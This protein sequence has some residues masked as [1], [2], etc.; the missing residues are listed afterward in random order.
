MTISGHIYTPE[1]LALVLEQIRH[2]LPWIGSLDH[3]QDGKTRLGNCSHQ[4][5]SIEKIGLDICGDIEL[6]N[7]D[8]GRLA[9][10]C[11][12]ARLPAYL[13]PFIFASKEPDGTICDDVKVVSLNIIVPD[14]EMASP[15]D[16]IVR[17]V[18]APE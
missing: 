16:I 9:E 18:F 3:P 1:V 8:S 13:A 12:K 15:L 14:K 7:T 4:T 17:E 11:L 2:H 6:F 10:A 5:L